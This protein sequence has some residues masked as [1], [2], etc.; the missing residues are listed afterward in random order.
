MPDIEASVLETGEETPLSHG[1]GTGI[2]MIR[3][4]VTQSGGEITVDATDAGT[5]LI[6]RIPEGDAGIPGAA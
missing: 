3:M 5:T 2:W 6:F 4:L 1:R